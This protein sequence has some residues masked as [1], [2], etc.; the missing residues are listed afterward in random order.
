MPSRDTLTTVLAAF[1]AGWCVMSLEMLD[2]R[3]MAPVFG[4]TVY[5]WGAIIGTALAFMSAGYWFGGRLGAGR[6]AG[7]A[8]PVLLGIAALAASLTPWMGRAVSAA[9]EAALGPLAGAVGASAVLIGP[10][11]FTLAA[12]S[13]LCVARLA[14]REGAA[15]AAGAVS[16]AQALG[17]IGGTFYAAFF[18][19]PQMGLTA[20]YA[21][22]ALLAALAAL[23]TGL[24][25]VLAGLALLPLLPGTLAERAQAARYAAYV[26]TP[27]NTIMVWDTPP[28]TYLMLNSPIAVQSMRRRD[29]AETGSYWELLAATPALAEGRSALFLG[30]AGGSAIEATLRA[31]PGLRAQGVEIDPGVTAVARE[32]FAL[33]IPVQHADARRALAGGTETFDVIVVDLYATGQMPAHVATAEF[34]QAVSRRLAPGGVVALNVFGAGDPRAVAGP[35]AAT[36]RAVFPAVLAVR[37]GSGNTILLAWNEPMPLATAVARLRAA[38]APARRVAERMAATL[39]DAAPLAAGHQP[40]TDERSDLELRAARAL[41]LGRAAR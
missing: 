22:A 21:S 13:P 31:W 25:P 7:A 20:G 11:A 26:E 12:V 35:L 28:A 3:L 18:A 16:A 34:F 38:P 37:S 5:Q 2:G 24:R 14:G 30:V 39:A 19:I 32:Y 4:Q 9:A 36:L 27:Y 33:T 15:P 17:S 1:A 41:A 8:L 6:R 10:P 29:G 23:L 40:L